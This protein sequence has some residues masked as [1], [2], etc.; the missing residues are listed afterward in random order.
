MLTLLQ[1]YTRTY[2]EIFQGAMNPLHGDESGLVMYL[3]F[4]GETVTQAIRNKAVAT[5]DASPDFSGIQGSVPDDKL[6][7]AVYDPSPLDDATWNWREVSYL[8][9]GDDPIGG[10]EHSVEVV[11]DTLYYIGSGIVV[12]A[13][14]DSVPHLQVYGRISTTSLVSMLLFSA[15]NLKYRQ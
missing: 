10:W 9:H 6:V 3:D 5:R 8:F 4:E 12:C 1:N 14:C 7:A 11:G 15:A 2:S 13:P